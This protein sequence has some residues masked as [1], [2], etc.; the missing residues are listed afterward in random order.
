MNVF[1][2]D[3]TVKNHQKKISPATD[4]G[5]LLLTDSPIRSVQTLCIYNAKIIFK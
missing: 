5:A 4:M 2:G 3:P 1:R